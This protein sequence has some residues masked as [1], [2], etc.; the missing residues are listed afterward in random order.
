LIIAIVVVV[1]IVIALSWALARRRRLAVRRDRAHG[2][3]QQGQRTAID[4]ESVRARDVAA[5]RGP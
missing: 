2:L 4:A 1:L 3:R 5:G